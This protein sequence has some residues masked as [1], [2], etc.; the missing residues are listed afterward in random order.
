MYEECSI[1]LGNLNSNKK[2][3]VRTKCNHVYHMICLENWLSRK[4]SC[5]MCRTDIYDYTII[6]KRKIFVP[7]YI[8]FCF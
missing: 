8:R 3:L 4:E 2:M 1:C 6:N 7:W 5:P